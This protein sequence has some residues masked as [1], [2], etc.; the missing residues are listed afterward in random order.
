[1]IPLLY[2]PISFCILS[3]QTIALFSLLFMC[4][5]KLLNY[6]NNSNQFDFASKNMTDSEKFL[7]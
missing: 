6:V 2:V 5:S 3:F 1:M 7:D 4:T